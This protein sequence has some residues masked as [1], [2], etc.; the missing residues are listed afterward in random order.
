M[1][2]RMTAAKRRIVT[3]G[4]ISAL[5]VAVVYGWNLPSLS[6]RR[7]LS[8][9]AI[10]KL[11]HPTRIQAMHVRIWDGS[12]APQIAER[13]PIVDTHTVSDAA[14]A[15]DLMNVLL[16]PATYDYNPNH[17]STCIF[18]PTVG[19]R[20]FSGNDF[21]DVLICFHCDQLE[22]FDSTGQMLSAYDVNT[23]P[24]RA[25]LLKVV[26]SV[27]PDDITIQSLS[28]VASQPAT[29]PHAVATPASR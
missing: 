13:Y 16:D 29:G 9:T 11:S 10:A 18:R 3:A 12:A 7:R 5:I 2:F 19:F 26:K 14:N 20:V 21:I 22:I 23:H 28:V 8:G 6:M 17:V 25:N 4:L 24:G 1:S 27:F 15:R